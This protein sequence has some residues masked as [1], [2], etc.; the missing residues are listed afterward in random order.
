MRKLCLAS[1]LL[2]S[3]SITAQEIKFMG[4][5]LDND[6]NSFCKSLS[7]KG[8]KKTI[9]RFEKKEYVG[10]FA[11]YPDCR[12]IVNGTTDKK[13]IKSVE[14]IFESVTDKEYE[15]NEAYENIISQYSN[16]YNGKLVKMPSD[17]VTK[18]MNFTEYTITIDAITIHIQ[19]IGPG[20]FDKEECSMSI[21]YVNSSANDTGKGTD[22]SNDI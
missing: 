22:Y 17:D 18:M 7:S 4:L 16:K 9:D 19:K 8:L 2:I 21:V 10:T 1:L 12:I 3:L 15:R 5:S 11:T 13:K 6:L 14:V 20:I